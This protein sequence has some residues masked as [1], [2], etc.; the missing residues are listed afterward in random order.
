MSLPK[1]GRYSRAECNSLGQH[2]ALSETGYGLGGGCVRCGTMATATGTPG[3]VD[4]FIVVKHES[5]VPD[6]LGRL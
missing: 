3:Q 4:Y 2:V 6:P 5:E 1:P